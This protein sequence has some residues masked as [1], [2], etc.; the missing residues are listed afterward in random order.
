MAIKLRQSTD[1]QEIPLGYFVDSTDGDTEETA[2]TIANTDILLWK[3]GA[4]SLVSKNSGGATHMS[5]GIY[6]CTLDAT[7]TDTLGALIVFVHVSGALAVK[8]ECEVQTANAYDS[9]IAGTDNLQ[10][11]TVQIE[12]TDATDQLDA[13]D[14]NPPSAATIADAVWDEATSGHVGA[15]SFG[16]E[17]QAHALSS[18]IS[19]LNDIS[20]AEVNAEVVDALNVDAYSEPTGAPPVSASLVAKIGYLYMRLRNKVT[21]TSSALTVFDDGGVS[22]F[23]KT[24]SDDGTTFTEA[25]AA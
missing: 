2:L 3:M 4:T 16:E 9:L 14:G 23:S 5:N 8:V 10:V 24:L 15:G 17:V 22:E 11:D 12:G 18:E 13:H 20:A 6:Y 19:A 1:G 21:V 7:D 25:E